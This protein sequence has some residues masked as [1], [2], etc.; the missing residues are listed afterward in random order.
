MKTAPS[1]PGIGDL[2]G[3]A[4][5]DLSSVNNHVRLEVCPSSVKLS[6]GT[7]GLPNTVGTFEMY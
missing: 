7:L 2:T 1:Q 4:V 5:E 6:D 3:T